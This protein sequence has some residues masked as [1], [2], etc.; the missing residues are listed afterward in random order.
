[1]GQRD[2]KGLTP[3]MLASLHGSLAAVEWLL[4]QDPNSHK[5]RSDH[6]DSALHFSL[7]SRA[8][9]SAEVTVKLLEAGADP[10]ARREGGGTMLHRLVSC[11]AGFEVCKN[12]IESLLAAGVDIDATTTRL[13]SP[14]FSAV[15]DS[16]LNVIRAL[17]Y[18]GASVNCTDRFGSGICHF[19]ASFC[20]ADTLH[21]LV[22]HQ[23]FHLTGI[24]PFLADKH[25]DSPWDQFIISLHYPMQVIKM[26]PQ[27][28][29]EKCRTFESFYVGIRKFKVQN[30]VAALQRV[31]KLLL[32]GELDRASSELLILAKQKEPRQLWA[33]DVVMQPLRSIHVQIGQGDRSDALE[34]IQEQIDLRKKHLGVSPWQYDSRWWHLRPPVVGASE[35][36]WQRQAEFAKRMRKEGLERWRRSRMNSVSYG[37]VASDS[38][39]VTTDDDGSED[40]RK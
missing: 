8:S 28:T 34:A 30:D 23:T 38:E 33:T 24:D 36:D 13:R 19:V 2:G 17:V 9:A 26:Y 14:L 7:G 10:L 4:E 20:D 16:Q 15:A 3:L 11:E 25:G 37:D 31:G 18:M 40:E 32:V 12:K 22:K 29:E 5:Q 21:E 1:M 35:Q 6:G 39:W 27:V